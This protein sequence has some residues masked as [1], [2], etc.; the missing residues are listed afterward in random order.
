MQLSFAS[1]V[2]PAIPWYFSHERVPR[3]VHVT[4]QTKLSGCFFT[5]V[6]VMQ[7]FFSVYGKVANIQQRHLTAFRPSSHDWAITC[8]ILPEILSNSTQITTNLN[9]FLRKNSVCGLAFLQFPINLVQIYYLMRNED[10]ALVSS[11][12]VYLQCDF[13]TKKK[14]SWDWQILRWVC[15]AGTLS[16]LCKALNKANIKPI[17]SNKQ[18]NFAP[19]I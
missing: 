4:Q 16:L 18:R 2:S 15:V 6:F 13:I 14:S 8:Y 5:A 3:E 11:Y 1:W 7:M 10:R 17:M 19:M 9:V 12:L